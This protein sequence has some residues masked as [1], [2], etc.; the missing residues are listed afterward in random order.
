LKLVTNFNASTSATLSQ[1]VGLAGSSTSLTSS[2]NPSVFGQT[3]T[4]TAT[5]SAVAPG[6]GA[7]TGTVTFND[8]GASIGSATL[9]GGVGTFSTLALSV[10]THPI[11]AAYASDGNFASS[12]SGIVTQT[13]NKDTTT[14]T[15]TSSV[16]PSSFSQLVTFTATIT[17]N[18]P[19]SGTPTGTVTFKDNGVSI[20]TGALAGGVATFSISTLA[21]GTHPITASYPG[22]ANFIGNVSGIYTQTVIT[23]STS[24]SLTSSANPSVFNQSVTF[25]DTVSP[26]G[27]GGTPSGSVTFKDG[28]STLAVV[29][30]SADVATYTT[31]TL[32]VAIHTITAIYSGDANFMSSTASLSQTVTKD[33]TTTAVTS[34]PNPANYFQSVTF[35]ATVT[36]NSPGAGTP[37]GSVTF[38]DNGVSIAS[39][40]LVAGKASF[41]TSSLP[42]GTDAI[43]VIYAGDGNFA[44]STSTVL[45]QIINKTTTTGTLTSSQSLSIF[46]Q[47]VTFTDMLSTDTHLGTPPTGTVTFLDGSA[48]VGTGT[49][50]GGVATLTTSGLNAAVHFMSAVYGG[51]ANYG[52]A[53]SNTIT[54]NVIKATPVST[55]TSSS[56]PSGPGLPVTFTDTLTNLGSGKATGSVTFKDSSTTLGTGTLSN[57]VA[58]FTAS[59][60]ANGNHL[61]TAVYGGDSNVVGV[62]SA[63][64]TQ[65]VAL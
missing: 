53:T 64:F 18:S 54:Q 2:V 50:S 27:A 48:T 10:G 37:T 65:T 47:P 39:A 44:T 16:N 11:T 29:A 21:L 58:T 12:T 32:A 13:V 20:G 40:N 25:T 49:L 43:T 59:S 6:V 38:D 41:T 55:V 51:D 45:T 61:I 62:T 46:G 3:V 9:A 24:S 52:A 7:P 19:G 17:A 8:N 14:V 60:L 57:N 30:L 33:P 35:S 1:T 23:D 34:A 63:T 26:I 4:F 56:N 28:A 36:A 42:P 15:L 31:S 5:V 22:D